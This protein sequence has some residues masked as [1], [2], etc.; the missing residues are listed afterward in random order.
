MR[1]VV[2]LISDSALSGSRFG[3]GG[4]WLG[5]TRNQRMTGERGS[6]HCWVLRRHPGGVFSGVAAPGLDRLTH[7]DVGVVVVGGVG[8]WLCVECCIVD[9]S[10]L[11]WLKCLRAHGGCLGIRSR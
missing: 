4:A 3:A 7:P 9:A 2:L 8:V 10:I 11:L 5:G 1:C 6:A